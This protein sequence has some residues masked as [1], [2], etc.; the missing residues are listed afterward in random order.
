MTTAYIGLGSNVGDRVSQLA[1]AVDAI[2]HL[3][4]THVE[5][6]SRAYETEPAYRDDQAPFV[7]AVVEVTTGLTPEDLMTELLTVEDSM[8]RE[9]TI[10]NGPRI[11]DLDLLLFGTEEIESADLVVP[12]P[13]I[14]E[15]DF[16]VTPLLEVAPHAELP[17]GTHLRRSRARVGMV[18]RDL[19]RLPDAGLDH[20]VPVEPTEWVA[21]AQSEGPQTALAGFDAALDFKREVLEEEGIPF[22]FEPFAPGTD[23]DMLGRPQVIS[24]VVPVDFYDRAA[25]LLEAVEDAETIESFDT[26]PEA[27]QD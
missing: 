16:V 20:N 8:G 3:P 17:D 14:Q 12:H 23:V 25:A 13:G 5:A 18:I 4:S 26:S 24:L 15:R 2:G 21:V 6:V 1:R 27:G 9:R 22:A 11:I 7:N 19:G 10:E